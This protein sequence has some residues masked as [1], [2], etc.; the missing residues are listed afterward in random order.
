[1][2]Q[3]SIGAYTANILIS[4]ALNLPRRRYNAGDVAGCAAAYLRAC[5]LAVPL[6]SGQTRAQLQ[7]AMD[8]AQRLRTGRRDN[9][10]AWTLRR[11]FDAVL[12]APAA[13]DPAP[14]PS[15]EPPGAA[16]A[17]AAEEMRR[18]IRAGAPLFNGGDSAGCAALYEACCRGAEPALDGAARERA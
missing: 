14:V 3:H 12:G 6:A 13:A 5:S 1:M 8:E 7:R 10:A 4:D 15:G 17:G 2:F 9:D 11:A 16:M 18:A